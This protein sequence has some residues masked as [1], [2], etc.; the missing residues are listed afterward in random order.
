M[1]LCFA[2]LCSTEAFTDGAAKILYKKSH[3][4][5]TVKAGN[6]NG[7]EDVHLLILLKEH[8]NIPPFSIGPFVTPSLRAHLRHTVNPRP[9]DIH[10]PL[11]VIWPSQTTLDIADKK[12]VEVTGN[13]V[14]FHLTGIH[15]V[16][17][18][19]VLS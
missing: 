4:V 7:L 12:I 3:D 2:L 17:L 19:L 10:H 5:H 9:T 14:M 13:I 11:S 18:A 16:G 15:P 8:Y 6:C 1:F